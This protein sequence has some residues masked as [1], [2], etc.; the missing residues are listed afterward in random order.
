[1]YGYHCYGQFSDS[2]N[3]DFALFKSMKRTS[4]D[5]EDAACLYAVDIMQHRTSGSI[6]KVNTKYNRQC[7]EKEP[8]A[9]FGTQIRQIDKVFH[10]MM[11]SSESRQEWLGSRK[12]PS[13]WCVMQLA[14]WKDACG[15]EITRNTLFKQRREGEMD[16]GLCGN[17][18][19]CGKK[20]SWRCRD[21]N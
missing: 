8:F 13:Y 15:G 11:S 2:Q 12:G 1:M 14:I 6:N 19:R 3:V 10:T 16:R 7:S 9:I 4:L 17:R 18:D 20:A 21:S 5:I